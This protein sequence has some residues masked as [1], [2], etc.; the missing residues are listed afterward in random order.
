M[1]TMETDIRKQRV[2]AAFFG[3]YSQSRKEVHERFFD[4]ANRIKRV[5]GFFDVLVGMHDLHTVTQDRVDSTQTLMHWCVQNGMRRCAVSAGSAVQEMQLKRVSGK[6]ELFHYF[7]TIE[8][9]EA[10][11]DQQSALEAASQEADSF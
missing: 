9:G 2:K 1:Y 11:L 6:N 4:A 3:D 8:A 5:H 10:W 7:P